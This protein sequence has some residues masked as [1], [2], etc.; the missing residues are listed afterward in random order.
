[1]KAAPLC[2][3]VHSTMKHRLHFITVQKSIRQTC[4]IH[5]SIQMHERLI[6]LSSAVGGE[7][8]GEEALP[9]LP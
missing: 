8:R 6:T 1:M 2:F 5:P 3:P 7:G 9:G 4:P